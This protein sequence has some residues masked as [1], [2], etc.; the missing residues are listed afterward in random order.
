MAKKETLNR[1][2]KYSTSPYSPAV[3]CNQCHA[4]YEL[5]E[6]R[7]QEIMQHPDFGPDN[8]DLIEE[9]DLTIK[10]IAIIRECFEQFCPS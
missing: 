4:L 5:L 6:K 1:R 9:L 7:R 10:R 2:I 3:F 8:D